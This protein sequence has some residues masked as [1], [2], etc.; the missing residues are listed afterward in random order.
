M[1]PPLGKA[2]AYFCHRQKNPWGRRAFREAG[3]GHGIE[4]L[5]G[6]VFLKEGPKCVA[7]I[8]SGIAVEQARMNSEG[9]ASGS[10]FVRAELTV[11]QSV[12]KDA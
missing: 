2:G 12:T 1:K 9:S 10:D 8:D 11:P 4:A 5:A 6:K 3:D 7:E